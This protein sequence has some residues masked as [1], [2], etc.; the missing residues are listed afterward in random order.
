MVFWYT[1]MIGRVHEI[2][3]AR[4]LETGYTPSPDELGK[5]IVEQYTIGIALPCMPKI[6]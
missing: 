1:K 5:I 4:E 2:L 6:A 3:P